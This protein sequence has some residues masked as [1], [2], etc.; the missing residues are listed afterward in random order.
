MSSRKRAIDGEAD[1]ELIESIDRLRQEVEV[2]D[3]S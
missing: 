2:Q 1:S 3:R